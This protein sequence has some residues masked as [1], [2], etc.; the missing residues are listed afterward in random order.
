LKKKTKPRE[1][2]STVKKKAWAAFS[3]YV[4]T[5]DCLRTTG[6]ASFGLCIT[7]GKRNHFK[8][9]QAGH[10]IAGRHNAVLFSEKGVH[11]QCYNCNINLK[12]ATLEYRRKIIEMY[13]EGF[14]EYLEYE[15]T[16]TV[17][18][19]IQD[20]KLIEK[21]Y[22]QKTEE[23]LTGGIVDTKYMK[24]QSANIEESLKRWRDNERTL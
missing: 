8:L 3:E 10:F 14:D 21:Y 22:K 2:L 23:L 12:G 19:S 15:A 5:R 11:A 9:L 24:N 13:G 6:C 17:K 18:L 1:K 20:C 7:C 4:R 16:R